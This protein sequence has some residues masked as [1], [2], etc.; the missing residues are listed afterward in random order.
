VYSAGSAVS[1]L[2]ELALIDHAADLDTVDGARDSDVIFVPSLAGLG[3]PFWAPDA[4]GGWLG[5]SLAS[6]RE[7]LVHAVVWGI[8]AQVAS[9]A[10]AMHKDMGR[11]LERLRVDG[12]L[13]RSASLMQAQAD[14]LQATVERYPSADATAL[15]VGAFA[16]LGCGAAQSPAEAV[17]EWV[18]DRVFEPQLDAGEAEELLARWEAAAASL[19]DLSRA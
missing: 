3:A 18:A 8:A 5:L 10:R 7:D 9:L 16:R 13:T 1:W 19:A 12:G 17:G 11:P 15:G 2:Q 6:R 14:L 4:R